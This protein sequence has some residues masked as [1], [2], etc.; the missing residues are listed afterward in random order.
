VLDPG[1][2]VCTRLTMKPTH[3]SFWLSTFPTRLLGPS[4][5][6]G[7]TYSLGLLSPTSGSALGC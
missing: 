6:S 1:S 5:Q 4:R 2:F 7:T 3:V